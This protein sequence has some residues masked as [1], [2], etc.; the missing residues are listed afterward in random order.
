MIKKNITIKKV[1]L[2]CILT[3]IIISIIFN[4]INFYITNKYNFP[5]FQ[6]Y[7]YKIDLKI[8]KNLYQYHTKQHIQ[9]FG[10][11]FYYIRNNFQYIKRTYEYVLSQIIYQNTLKKYFNTFNIDIHKKAIINNVMNNSKFK[12][13]HIFNKYKYIKFINQ[14][15]LDNQK[16]INIIKYKKVIKKI[17]ETIIYSDFILENEKKYI[18]QAISEK[19]I[20]KLIQIKIKPLIQK[21]KILNQ[22][23]K[24]HYEKN[25]KKFIY[26]EK[27][28]IKIIQF[29]KKKINTKYQG[30]YIKLWYKQYIN[31]HNILNKKRYIIIIF[32]NKQYG[33]KI[34]NKIIKK[35]I[36]I[37]DLLKNQLFIFKNIMNITDSLWIK[38]NKL[39]N[40]ITNIKINT[41]NKISNLIKYHSNFF[42]IKLYGLTQN[43]NKKI[44]NIHNNKTKNIINITHQNNSIQYATKQYTYYCTR[45]NIPKKINFQIIKKFIF[46]KNNMFFNKTILLSLNKINFIIL[47]IQKYQPQKLLPI[48]KIKN[49]IIKYIKIK[50]SKNIINNKS[51]NIIYQIQK[52][53][54]YLLKKNKLNFNLIKIYSKNK[55]EKNIFSILNFIRNQPKYIVI[56]IKNGN[57]L[58]IAIKKIEYNNIFTK[59]EKNI[60]FIKF[61]KNNYHNIT[62]TLL[63]N[64]TKIKNI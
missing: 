11:N 23:I 5:I 51:L 28:I 40:N 39:N 8:I 30:K 49:Q 7:S 54:Y 52:N 47:N 45:N 42:I 35:K 34:L 61:K 20:I 44:K 9:M 64:L 19:K 6:I 59:Q 32:K 56:H 24:F 14:N 1:I 25:Q 27:F 31:N 3:I 18:L 41:K 58:I 12:I 13:Y 17:I 4:S 2:F 53:N 38:K 43:H 50:K 10:K 60:L 21:Q 62:T 26:N 22:E 46:N 37:F 57:I 29:Q 48:K 16:Y 36:K 55:Y 33:L 15:N 63:K